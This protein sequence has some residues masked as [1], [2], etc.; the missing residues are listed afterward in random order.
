VV[1]QVAGRCGLGT[2]EAARAG[3]VWGIGVDTDQAALGPQVLSS[4]LK[5]FD[6]AV[7]ETV[8]AAQRGALAGRRN[9]VFDLRNGG[10]GLG[11]ISPEVPAAV[12]A[13][14]RRVERQIAAGRI[15]IPTEIS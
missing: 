9:A 15:S 8:R 14:V 11:R 12:V 5:R 2:L 13:Q 3:G 4:A 10:V 1:F 7:F 6:V